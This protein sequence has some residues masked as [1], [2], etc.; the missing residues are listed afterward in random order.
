[1]KRGEVWTVSG[2]GYAGRPL[3]AVIVQ[4]DRFDATASITVCYWSRAPTNSFTLPSTA[5]RS[6]RESRMPSSSS[7]PSSLSA[8]IKQVSLKTA[9][10][11]SSPTH[12]RQLAYVPNWFYN[13]AYFATK[14]WGW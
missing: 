7:T 9:L 11:P 10:S 1:M 2:A 4:D 5:A 12:R 14:S 3:P 13:E 8:E 6:S